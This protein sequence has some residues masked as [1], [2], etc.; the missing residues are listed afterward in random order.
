MIFLN[1]V[2]KDHLIDSLSDLLLDLLPGR[3]ALLLAGLRSLLGILLGIL[4]LL[5][6]SVYCGTAS[7]PCL[8]CHLHKTM[9]VRRMD[10]DS[11]MSVL[12]WD[13][14]NVL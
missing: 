6:C 10:V 12:V 9:F 14:T 5:G 8:L 7:L 13:I 2:V 11:G 4:Q 1:Q 3:L